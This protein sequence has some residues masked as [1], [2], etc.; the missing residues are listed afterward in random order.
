MSLI[1]I[2]NRVS[3]Q[4]TVIDSL[5]QGTK[6]VIVDYELDTLETLQNKIADVVIDITN[7]TNVGI[8]QENYNTGNYQYIGQFGQATL[9]DVETV[10]PE[11]ATWNDFTSLL[12]Y[13]KNVLNITNLDLM[14]CN[15]HKDPN[16]R[17]VIGKLEAV[18]G[19]VIRSSDDYTGS[20]EMGGNWILESDNV[21]LIGTYFTE[22]I[23]EYNFVL[24]GESSHSFIISS[25][26]KL[27]GYGNNNFGQ[28]GN[29]TQTNVGS[30]VS[31]NLPSDEIPIQI[32]C[33]N[34]H[35]LVLT[36]SGR[37]YACGK[38]DYGELGNSNGNSSYFINMELPNNK[39][40]I[41]VSAASYFSY[42][43]LD[44]GTVYSCGQN[45]FGQ[46]G[47]GDS[48]DKNSL[49]QMINPTN[50]PQRIVQ[51]IAGARHVVVMMEDGSLYSCGY[52]QFGQLGNGTI[53]PTGTVNS[54]ITKI[55]IPGNRIP[56]QVNC[57]S[58][59][60]I[61][62]MTDSTIWGCGHNVWGQLGNNSSINTGSLVQMINNTGYIPKQIACGSF[63]TFILM[64]N[65]TIYACGSN[66]N[67]QLMDGTGPDPYTP[68]VV[69]STLS[70]CTNIPGKNPSNLLNT[71]GATNTV[72]MTDGTVYKAGYVVDFNGVG[73]IS[74]KSLIQ[75]KYNDGTF[76]T[77]ASNKK[78]AYVL[79]SSL[80]KTYNGTNSF[81]IGDRMNK[82]IYTIE[83]GLNSSTLY[84]SSILGTTVSNDVGTNIGLNISNITLNDSN[85]LLTN[86]YK[87][88]CNILQA[89]LT[90][91]VSS[92]KQ[93][94]GTNSATALT[95]NYDGIVIGQVPNTSYTATY[96]GVDVGTR[97][98]TVTGFQLQ[99]SASFKSTNYS[100]ITTI[101][102]FNGIITQRVL[103]VSPQVL[104]KVYDGNTDARSYTTLAFSNIIG[105]QTPAYDFVATYNDADVG[106]NKTVTITYFEF[107]NN[108]PF[109]SGNYTIETYP[110]TNGK[111]IPKNLI[112]QIT[113]VTKEYDGTTDTGVVNLNFT[114]LIPGETANYTSSSVTFVDPNV[115]TDKTVSINFG[116][117]QNGSFKPTNYNIDT[118]SNISNKGTITA[119]PA[120]VTPATAFNKI[121]DGT[122]LTQVTLNFT[123]L[124]IG[125]TPIYNCP[126]N[127]TNYNFGNNRPVTVD[128]N[129]IT[130]TENNLFKP[131]NYLF[132]F[133]NS[134][135]LTANISKRTLTYSI[136]AFTKQYDGTIVANPVITFGGLATGEQPNYTSDCVYDTAD[137]G[138]G[139]TVTLNSF[140]LLTNSTTKFNPGNYEYSI[141]LV[142][143]NNAEITPRVLIPSINNLSKE[144]DGT[145]STNIT[146]TYNNLLSAQTPIYN[147][148]SKYSDKNSGTQK[149]ITVSNIV[150]GTNGNFKQ[151]NYSYENTL[152]VPNC[153]ILAKPLTA[154]ITSV[155]NKEYDGTRDAT[156][157][158]S[159]TGAVPTEEPSSSYTASFNT[160]N[161]GTGKQVTVNTIN[162]LTNGIFDPSNYTIVPGQ[163]STGTIT[164]KPL[165]ASVT[166]VTNKEYDGTVSAI[167]TL[168][169]T[170]AVPTETANYNCISSFDTPSIGTGKQVT[171]NTINLL[172]NGIFN[173]GNYTVLPGQVSTGNITTKTLT[174]SVATVTTKVYDGT[175]VAISTLLFNGVAAGEVANYNCTSSF[176]TPDAG[177][178]K[179]VTI[180]NITLN[181]NMP[182]IG[183]NYTVAAGQVSTGTITAKSLTATIRSVANK[184]YD[185]TTTAVALL[186][187]TGSITGET[188]LWTNTAA[189]NTKNAGS[190]RL[191]TV[192]SISL[193]NNGAFI[194]TNYS[195]AI[196]QTR[197][198]NITKR[199]LGFKYLVKARK[200]AKGNKKATMVF[201]NYNKL[202]K[203]IVAISK[204]IATYNNDAIGNNKPVTITKVILTGRDS[205]N[206]SVS[207]KYTTKG[208]ITK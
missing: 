77:N 31:I 48:V 207:S 4:K 20:S 185:G 152:V 161:A 203:D 101:A 128:V 51:V 100:Y 200:Y 172:T 202:A 110:V 33:G 29:G 134:S 80:E 50:P 113:S 79:L 163:V 70:L 180:N 130:Y 176:N 58:H 72:I 64:D 170:G 115:G 143:V 43:L 145:D 34:S 142:T 74:A 62:L 85:Y 148:T 178:G 73:A 5:L 175:T 7:I 15:I 129:N 179:Q 18:S 133:I 13:F 104:D 91:T 181:D 99:D 93:Y 192:R 38:N 169:F 25:D 205:A 171:V 39:L 194:G 52:N 184:V 98:V 111:I 71:G 1:L 96:D 154:T 57:C 160:A 121:Y 68:V 90:Y 59:D 46:L 94:D 88:M 119:K 120:T 153:I 155:T 159:F 36:I 60:I 204:Y 177:I 66:T 12:T 151:T 2:D 76:V 44:D 116:F 198:A 40:A 186:S 138:T 37:V 132:T 67:G 63:N 81:G 193:R 201:L 189:F 69:H 137:V 16:W 162:L 65:D 78:N 22:S 164:A 106:T 126:G 183:S 114:G 92:T 35:T 103:T 23:K 123:G 24:G 28:L 112:V 182:F 124:V 54:T 165:T 27:Y 206:Y 56:K 158:L 195:I 190:N 107:N 144:Y 6:Y 157:A 146:L 3:D 11:I 47:C 173:P 135:S 187:V 42:V 45:Q 61:V 166:A 139:K 49:T 95:F 102:P 125:Q 108:I 105:E 30:Y 136:D 127:F 17:Y 84:I 141:D 97:V 196:G 147:Y 82:F 86:S 10:D 122:N 188:P 53:S 150:L 8:F 118:T 41:Q 55:T 109:F 149:T 21:D 87:L 191:V 156:V 131:T 168:S 197:L 174:A 9:T 14:G 167:V 140:N 117:V 89:S 75:A 26:N 32:S 83:Y 208:N 19:L 199:L